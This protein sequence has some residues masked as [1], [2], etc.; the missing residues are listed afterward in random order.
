MKNYTFHWELKDLIVQFISALDDSI[1]RR[2]DENKDIEKEI[3]VRYVYAPKS[4][5]LHWMVNDQQHITLPVA[6][7][8]I[9][10]ISRD[11]SR[12]F[13]KIDGPTYMGSD[14]TNPFQPVP[15]DISVS[16]SLLAKYQ[17]DMDQ[18]ISNFVPYFDPY[19]ILS[20]KHPRVERE[21]RSEVL[22]DGSLNFNYP[23]EIQATES[24]RIGI[25]TTFTIKGWLFK[26][27]EG[28]AADVRVFSS[29]MAGNPEVDI[30]TP[31]Y[32]DVREGLETSDTEVKMIPMLNSTDPS[33]IT[34]GG[35]TVTAYGGLTDQES[36]YL[37]GSSAMV[38]GM[39]LVDLFSHDS[40]LS[41]DNPPFYGRKITSYVQEGNSTS[42]IEIPE[43]G[44]T[45]FLDIIILNHAGYGSIIKNAKSYSAQ[46]D[47]LFIIS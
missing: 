37:S 14:V 6:S 10:G 33:W 12:V 43:L 34:S 5:V 25:D 40:S 4:R 26:K 27:S 30:D 39:E 42:I 13:N 36:M 24:Y 1:V 8:A 29:S 21:I 23:S 11:Q 9:T 2:Y 16:L 15:V 22:W 17:N 38:S 20:W 41:A 19:I 32:E 46:K 28:Q 44:T 35:G 18:M 7:I 3:A 45:G 31:N 47:G